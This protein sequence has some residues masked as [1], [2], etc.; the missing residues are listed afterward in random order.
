MLNEISGS[1][2]SRHGIGQGNTASR[3]FICDWVERFYQAEALLGAPHPEIPNCW[4]YE[5]QIK[6][7]PTEDPAGVGMP[8][9]YTRAL[10]EASYGTDFTHA[11]ANQW[12]SSIPRPT[13]RQN[14]SLQI[15][16]SSSV[17]IM[18][19][20]AGNVR[21]ADNTDGQ[22][23]KPVPE[24]ESPAGRFF[25]SQ[26]EITLTWNYVDDPPD[27]QQYEGAVNGSTF[28]G[29]APQTLLF[30]G[31]ELKESTKAEIL[32]PGSWMVTVKLQY[33]AIKV[34]TQTYGWNHEYSADG[35]KEVLMY[36]GSSWVPRYRVVD[37]TNMFL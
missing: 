20:P 15:A 32:N 31:Y 17:E 1:N 27:F 2:S 30:G 3:Q 33:R 6:P 11:S 23:D 16:I 24:D 18:R 8:I 35:W 9:A 13:I 19:F 21:W 12:P 26:Q 29:K 4:C 25:V 14:T 36:D 7:F 34:G 5:V 37:F 22:P 10:L 28:L